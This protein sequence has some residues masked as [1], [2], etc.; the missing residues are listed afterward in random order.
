MHSPARHRASLRSFHTAP[1][2]SPVDE[3]QHQ[4]CAPSTSSSH[5]LLQHLRLEPAQAASPTQCHQAYWAIQVSLDVIAHLQAWLEGY[6]AT[7]AAAGVLDCCVC[8]CCC[9]TP[10]PLTLP[11]QCSL[12]LAC[13]DLLPTHHSDQ[14]RTGT[15]PEGRQAGAII[16][17]HIFTARGDTCKREGGALATH[18]GK[19]CHLTRRQ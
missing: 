19:E 2:L 5:L 10:L 4:V 17:L 8:I 16:Q 15:P 9:L 18:L 12:C 3:G 6:V 13:Q 7:A 14:H 11:G 1:L